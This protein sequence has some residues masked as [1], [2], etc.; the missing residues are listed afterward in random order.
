[1]ARVILLSL[2]FVLQ[3]TTFAAPADVAQTEI[4]HLLS[5]VQNSKARFMRNGDEHSGKD[6]AGHMKKKYNHFKKE[7]KTAEDFI[8]KCAAKSELSRKA[9]KIKE[10]DG[11]VVD[12]K[13]WF[14]ARLADYRKQPR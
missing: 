7:I 3:L 5:T 9:Y 11:T 14:L 13:E 6:A 8:E 10:P 12:S 1:M 2:V 4:D